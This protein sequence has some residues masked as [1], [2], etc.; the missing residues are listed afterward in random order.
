M[1]GLRDSEYSQLV[2]SQH[3]MARSFVCVI[4]NPSKAVGLEKSFDS[5]SNF[6]VC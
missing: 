3:Q 1:S 5:R 2:N 4:K 6:L